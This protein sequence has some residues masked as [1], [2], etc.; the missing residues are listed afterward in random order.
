MRHWG[1]NTHPLPPGVALFERVVSVH[2]KNVI[3]TIL[4]S[5]SMLL[6]PY[7]AMA[8]NNTDEATYRIYGSLFND[9]GAEAGSTSVKVDSYESVW[10]VDGQYEINGLTLG[11]HVIRAY[12]MNDGHTVIYRTIYVTGDTELDFYQGSNWITGTVHHSTNDTV[13]IGLVESGEESSITESR[14][15]F[16]P[17]AVHEYCTLVLSLIHI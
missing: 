5:T 15:E 17:Y 7:T 2:T 9:L 1:G 8:D 13:S 12:F 16:G 11:E 10:S 4:F 14:F 6:L 3:L